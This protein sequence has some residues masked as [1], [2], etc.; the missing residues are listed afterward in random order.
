MSASDSFPTVS[1]ATLPTGDRFVCLLLGAAQTVTFGTLCRDT[2]PPYGPSGT[3]WS[4]ARSRSAV[5]PH[6]ARGRRRLQGVPECLARVRANSG[7]LHGNPGLECAQCAMW[8]PGLLPNTARWLHE[9]HPG[10]EKRTR[11]RRTAAVPPM[12]RTAAGGT[13]GSRC[14]SWCTDRRLVHR[15]GHVPANADPRKAV[16]VPIADAGVAPPLL[17]ARLRELAVARLTAQPD[18]RTT[19][20]PP[21]AR[22]QPPGALAGSV[23]GRQPP[24]G[25]PAGPR[26][27]RLPTGMV[28]PGRAA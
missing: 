16:T 25:R 6:R 10:A 5:A 3:A 22:V 12:P 2:S 8:T 7:I 26:C 1:G 17:A 15:A 13:D 24:D 14:D 20:H 19:M 11:A 18:R 9:R 21:L 23:A 4:T 28:C 27:G